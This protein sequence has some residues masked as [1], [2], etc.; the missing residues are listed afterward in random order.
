MF[1]WHY[2]RLGELLDKLQERFPEPVWR[3]LEQ[4]LSA[5][6]A[7]IAAPRA[8]REAPGS[9]ADW[10]AWD[11]PFDTVPG[12]QIDGTVFCPQAVTLAAGS[13]VEGAIW[14]GR[15]ITVERNVVVEGPVVSR[16]QI[17]WQG[18]RASCLV[19]PRILLGRPAFPLDV[20]GSL[21]C[22]TLVLGTDAGISGTLGG[23]LA[24]SARI[25]RRDT[26]QAIRSLLVLAGSAAQGLDVPCAVTL[27]ERARIDYLSA[28]G[29]VIL[30]EAC[31]A[32][33]VAGQNVVL[34]A[35]SRVSHVHARGS[36]V[37]GPGSV[38]QTAVAGGRIAVDAAA[39]VEGDLIASASGEVELGGEGWYVDLQ[40]QYRANVAA[41]LDPG[42]LPE[43]GASE[44]SMRGWAAVRCLPRAL[45]RQLEGLY[46]GWCAALRPLPE[47]EGT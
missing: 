16:E 37:L 47:G 25:A 17:D 35:G 44:G 19:A 46:G 41:L 13:L 38:V 14:A 24:V 11:R 2:E 6:S 29:D 1:L 23:T 34:G 30:G 27:E 43:P 28:A 26:G 33:S 45:Y 42:A 22:Q 32:E 7:R 9:L 8:G 4:A 40:V 12:E 10:A 31:R 5:H 36:L 20:R 39:R 15:G 3:E 21:L 18:K